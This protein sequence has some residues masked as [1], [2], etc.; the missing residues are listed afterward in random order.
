MD[1]SVL[2]TFTCCEEY[3]MKKKLLFLLIAMLALALT[4]Y[5]EVSLPAS[6]TTIEDSA[7]EEDSSLKGRVTLPGKVATVGNRAFAGTG[8]HAL[9]L[10]TSCKTVD[11]SVL[12]DTRAAYLYLKSSS[13]KISGSLQ[14]VAYVF[15]PAFGSA[16]SLSNF[17][18]T[19]TLVTNSGFY[20]S[21]TDGAAVPLCAVDGTSVSNAITIPK[22]VDG[23]PVRSLSTL[24]LNGC[25]SLSTVNIPG[26]LEA[27]SSVDATTYI[28]MTATAPAASAGSAKVGDTLTWTTSVSGN[29]GETTY[30]WTFENESSSVSVSTTEPTI[31]FTLKNAGTCVVSVDVTDELGDTASATADALTVEGD[32]STVY[33]ALIVYNT[34]AGTSLALPGT[35]NDA[36][37]MKAMLSRMS[38][39]PYRVTTKSELSADGIVSAIRSA[40][41]AATAND[42]S[43]FYFSGHGQNAVGTSYHGALVGTGTTY[44]T[45]AKLK[46]T[47]DQI[48]GKK[49]VIIDSCHSGQMIGRSAGESAPV[50]K[51][52]LN[53]FNSKVVAAFSAQTRSANNLANSG[54]YVITAAHSTEESVNMGYDADADG[55]IDKHFGLFTY[56]LTQGS[57]WNMATNRV[58]SLSADSDSNG[59]ITLHEAYSYARYKALNSNPDQTAQVYPSNSSMVIWAK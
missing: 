40:F 24:I 20:Y 38:A 44:L 30:D 1:I 13:T 47:L 34:Y 51:S 28:T 32:G 11:G 39:T 33:R 23:Q 45:V 54:Y 31:E 49:I 58:R 3:D 15:G 19:E 57:G 36:A 8:L 42:V 6:L 21:V 7:F 56:M 55:I 37:G 53:A 25:S 18:A 26:Y 50:S 52:E 48:P 46:S 41:S 10:P 29:Y 35:D 43:L 14:D 17:Y 27:P 4:A 2:C 22:L 12:A 16:S 59:E 5:A 9:V